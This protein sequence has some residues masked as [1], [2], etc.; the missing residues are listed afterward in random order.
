[1]P[2][3]IHDPAVG[4]GPP[5]ALLAACLAIALALTACGPKPDQPGTAPADTKGPRDDWPAVIR[6]G[7]VPSEGGMDIVDRFAPLLAHLREELGHPVEARSAT[8]YI[9]V[10]TAMQNKQLDFAYFGPK[11]YVEAQVIAGAEAIVRELDVSGNPGYRGI[12]IVHKDA[13]YAT[14]EDLRGKKFGFVVQNSTSGY[15][16][17]AVGVTEATGIR[18][19]RFFGQIVWTGTHG[20][21]I[22]AL[23]RKELEGAATNDLDLRAMHE[24]G[25][26]NQEDFRVV[27][28]SELI[29]GSPIAARSDVPESLKNAMRSAILSM[30]DKQGALDAMSR[31]GFVEASDADYE[32]IRLLQSVENTMQEGG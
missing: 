31:G 9:G 30:N 22:Q 27:W 15:L 24:A 13:A 29:P 1:M 4:R 7:F 6:I 21:A 20:N 25:S 14:L 28:R 18:P 2:N 10:I 12:I 19:D 32:P 17:P 11:A 16:V 23:A 8:E 26:V 3:A 5:R